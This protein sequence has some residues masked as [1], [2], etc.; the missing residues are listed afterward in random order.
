MNAAPSARATALLTLALCVLLGAPALAA[1]AKP[2]KAE[3]A[4]LRTVER[5]VIKLAKYAARGKD[6][7]T[8]SQEL[9]L[10]LA[11]DPAS[12]KLK[13][14]AAKVER[15]TKKAKKKKRKARPPRASFLTKLAEKRAAAHETIALALAEA[16]IA[17]ETES[18]KRYARYVDLIQT[19]FK[20]KAALDRLDLVY[21]SPYYAWVS[22]AEAKVLLAGGERHKGKLL[23]KAAV[24]RLNASH[25][26]WSSPWIVS[27]EIHEIRTT[28][29]LREA[30]R[31]LAYVSSYRN[32][33]LKRFGDAWEFQAP[34]G[35]LPV[36]L[37]KTQ[38]D[39]ESQMRIATRGQQMG[40]QGIQGAAFYLQSTGSLNP[41]FV[42]YEPKEATGRTFKIERFEDLMIPLAHEVT[43]QIVFEYSKFAA[44]ATRQ[45]KHQ[46]WA[47]EAIANYM[48]YHSFD[49]TKWTLRRPNMIP[50]GGGMIE[51]PFAHCLHN[52][53]ELPTLE[54]FTAL[55]QSQFMTVNNY[56]QAATLASFLLEGEGGKYRKQFIKLL[57][58]VHRVKDSSST[59]NDAFPGVDRAAM[60]RE[61]VKFVKAI[62]LDS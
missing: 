1:P 13:R 54:R 31:T 16:A 10:G 27:D 37:T 55:S 61:W 32:Y 43:H 46:F 14:E 53:N 18:P 8:A 56:H 15:Q 11:V 44:D 45:I 58:T 9:E 19:R 17:I 5:E 12:K 28:V 21:F 4:A 59:W 39:L 51:G 2:L 47:V 22:Q 20:S 26:T 57:S 41:C 34:K 6:L 30:K 25:S 29:G 36:I 49:G 40:T 52:A 33:F 50:M 24:E 60:Q 3:R 7:A 38:A 42:T 62:K 35:K 48:G 23:D